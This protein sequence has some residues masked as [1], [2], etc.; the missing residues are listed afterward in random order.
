VNG[1]SVVHTPCF[2][3]QIFSTWPN[4]FYITMWESLPLPNSII[5]EKYWKVF[6]SGMLADRPSIEKLAFFFACFL[7]RYTLPSRDN[8]RYGFFFF[9]LFVCGQHL[10]KFY[11]IRALSLSNSKKLENVFLDVNNL[12]CQGLEW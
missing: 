1:S 8:L 2:F 10:Q 4:M 6:G 7:E 9:C 3:Q 5:E 12:N 11:I